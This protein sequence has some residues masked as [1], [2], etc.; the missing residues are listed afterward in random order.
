MAAADSKR[1]IKAATH[2]HHWVFRD[3]NG[4]VATSVASIVAQ[5]SK[6]SGGLA[7]ATNSVSSQGNTLYYLDLTATEMSADVV[8]LYVTGSS[9]TAYYCALEPEPNLTSGVAT[10]ATASSITFPST[11]SAVA[12]YYNGAPVEI[13]RGTG[14]GQSRTIRDYST[15]RVATID[16]DWA[17][18]PS[19]DSVFIV[20]P[21]PAPPLSS[22]ILTL[23]DMLAISGDTAAADLLEALYEGGAI[24]SSV[25]DSTPTTTAFDGASGLST[26]DDFYN[27]MMCV[28][29]SGP[30][31]G[32]PRRV[33]NYIGSSLTLEFDAAF[34]STP[35]NGNTF[36]L[37]GLVV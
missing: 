12:D 8:E 30:N 16:R 1:I 34:P 7:T 31:A 28:F 14:A 4:N 33:N 10:A 25:N 9:V 32:V 17:T 20:H 36:V 29:T 27:G 35:V 19:T 11:A 13:V 21:Q 3:S 5:V 15:G 18:N 6:D 22:S 24:S 23:S 2:R 37:I 26:T